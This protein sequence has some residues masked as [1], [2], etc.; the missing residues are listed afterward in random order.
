MRSAS[1]PHSFM[2]LSDVLV[3]RRT[4]FCPSV[5]SMDTRAVSVRGSVSH[6]AVNVCALQ[7]R[8]HCSGT[9]S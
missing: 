8:L 3:Y 4:T 5:L 7:V 9:D 6:A 1:G 2:W